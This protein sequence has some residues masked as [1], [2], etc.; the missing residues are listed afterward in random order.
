MFTRAD[1][2]T[3][4]LDEI[5]TATSAMQVKLLRVLQDFS[6]EPV[7]GSETKQVDTRVILATHENLEELV[8]SGKFR[9]DLF[10]RINVITI[11]L[12]PLRERREDIRPLAEQFL[13]NVMIKTR[14]NIDGFT[15]AAI[16]CLEAHHWPGNV[17]ELV[18]AVERAAFLGSGDRVDVSDFPPAVIEGA[19]RREATNSKDGS[20][21][22]VGDSLKAQLATPERRLILDALRQHNWR[23]DAAAKALGINRATLY[24]K[25]KRLGVDLAGIGPN[26]SKSL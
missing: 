2:G 11:Q 8:C 4:F 15:D 22:T 26:K 18:H 5:A 14:R 25:A 12:P 19:R 21:N 23:R 10:W 20:K 9:E 3:I 24:K 17:R 1:R 6:F 13:N 16:D 7:G